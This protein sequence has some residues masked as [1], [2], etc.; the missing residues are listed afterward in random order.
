MLGFRWAFDQFGPYSALGLDLLRVIGAFVLVWTIVGMVGL[1][2][3]C[4][5]LLF[6]S[7]MLGQFRKEGFWGILEE[8]EL[9]ILG[10]WLR[11]VIILIRVICIFIQCKIFG[12]VAEQLLLLQTEVSLLTITSGLRHQGRP[13]IQL[14]CLL[15]VVC[16]ML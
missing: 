16:Y 13:N 6:G 12:L 9:R 10:L 7:C 14:C 2:R 11:C 1:I 3:P 15:V 5:P 8:S 4:G